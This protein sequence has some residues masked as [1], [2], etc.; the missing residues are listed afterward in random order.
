MKGRKGLRGV[1][2]SDGGSGTRKRRKTRRR[3]GC[4]GDINPSVLVFLT[5]RRKKRAGNGSLGSSKA[6]RCLLVC[7]L[8][9]N[10]TGHY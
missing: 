9:G 3:W 5:E 1:S 7:L 4:R 6:S 8:G 2:V 10:R